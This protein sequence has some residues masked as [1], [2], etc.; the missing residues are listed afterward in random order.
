MFTV[1]EPVIFEVGEKVIVQTGNIGSVVVTVQR[2]TK[3]QYIL[4]NNQR[5]RKENLR[6]VGDRDSWHPVRLKK[7][8]EE[9][10]KTI[11]LERIRKGLDHHNWKDTPDDKILEIWGI[12]KGGSDGNN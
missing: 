12:L 8:T 9:D 3:T 1:K 11:R 6:L 7:A 5:F 4:S 10:L 2:E